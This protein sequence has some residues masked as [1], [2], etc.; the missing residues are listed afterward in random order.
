ML[1][2]KIYKKKF[3]GKINLQ[4]EKKVLYDGRPIVLQKKKKEKKFVLDCIHC[5]LTEYCLKLCLK[6]VQFA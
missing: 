1:Y 4:K 3:S 6:V 5:V 2:C